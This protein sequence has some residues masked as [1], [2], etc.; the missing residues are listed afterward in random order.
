MVHALPVV[1]SRI[2]WEAVAPRSSRGEER[3][4]RAESVQ[5]TPALWTDGRAGWLAVVGAGVSRR[6]A[7][8]F[9]LWLQLDLTI[10]P[11]P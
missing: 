7:A 3:R 8:L 11:L 4:D 5:Q 6:S 2:T 1:L 10:P 9:G